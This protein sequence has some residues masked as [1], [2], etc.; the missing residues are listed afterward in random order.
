[1]LK[2]ACLFVL[3]GAVASEDLGSAITSI[4]Q[5]LQVVPEDDRTWAALAIAYVE[6]AIQEEM[7][8]VAKE[9]VDEKLLAE[10][11][12]HV[13]Y[14]FAGQLSEIPEA[15]QDKTALELSAGQFQMILDGIDLT[16]VRHFKR[17]STISA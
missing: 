13:K 1:M 9:G 14:A 7:A 5:H 11:L 10:V 8:R 15:T 12:S 2:L 16:R 3:S 6:Q 4:Q 17:F